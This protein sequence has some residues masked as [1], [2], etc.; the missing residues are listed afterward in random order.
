MLK[1]YTSKDCKK[2]IWNETSIEINRVCSFKGRDMEP[3]DNK[4]SAFTII[5]E[6]RTGE[7]GDIKL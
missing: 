5:S 1:Y 6:I 7:G 4:Q 2:N 3:N